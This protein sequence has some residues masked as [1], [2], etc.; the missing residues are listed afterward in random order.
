MPCRRYK[1]VQHSFSWGIGEWVVMSQWLEGCLRRS[2]FHGELVRGFVG[3]G[4]GFG[5][6]VEDEALEDEELVGGGAAEFEVGAG[7]EADG[8]GEFAAG[9]VAAGLFDEVFSREGRHAEALPEDLPDGAGVANVFFGDD[10]HLAEGAGEHV[11]MAD[12]CVFAAVGG[13]EQAGGEA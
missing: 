8:S 5:G 11:E 13:V 3:G 6:E 2:E 7:Y 4:F 10:E 9:L 1:S 12:G